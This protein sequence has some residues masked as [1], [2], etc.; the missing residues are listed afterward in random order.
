M[1]R[2]RLLLTLGDVAGV[3]PEVAA[4]AL[5]HAHTAA[6]CRPAVIGDAAVLRRAFALPP[7]VPP[8]GQAA[9]DGGGDLRIEEVKDPAALFDGPAGVVRCFDPADGLA[10]DVRPRE[11]SGAAGKAAHDWLVAAADLCLAGAAEGIVTAPLNKAALAAGGVKHPGHTEI[12]AERCGRPGEPAEVRMTL[13][14][15]PGPANSADF[16]LGPDGLTVA[17]ATLHTSIASVP[18]LLTAD[19]VEGTA[20]L[21]DVFLTRIA[22]GRRRI[23]VCALNPHGGEGG[24]FGGEEEETIAPAVER[25]RAKGLDVHGPI[26]ADTLFRQAAAGAFDAVAAIYH[27]QGHI[28]LRLIGWG[29]AVNVTLG[30]PI[31]RTSPS[32]GTAFDI[33]WTGAADPEGMIG[34]IEVAAKLAALGEPHPERR[35]TT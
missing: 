23:G 22:A 34:A 32:H 26:P 24:L 13:H 11:I 6:C 16:P 30:L 2:P 9:S 15:P 35:E 31:V 18:G 33:A 17:H 7:A 29:R 28:A 21:L 10:R 20:R 4:G 12:L 14:L 25:L 1:S 27:D 19:R 8:A 3:G 5:R